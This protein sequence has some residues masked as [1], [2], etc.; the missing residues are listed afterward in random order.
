MNPKR[1]FVDRFPIPI[2]NMVDR[3]ER[4]YITPWSE[5]YTGKPS[6]IKDEDPEAR[7]RFK[8]KFKE[9]LERQQREHEERKERKREQRKRRM[10]AFVADSERINELEEYSDPKDLELCS[11][12]DCDPSRSHDSIQEAPDIIDNSELEMLDQ[13]E[14]KVEKMVKMLSTK[15]DDWKE[16]F[17]E[18][19]IDMTGRCGKL[20]RRNKACKIHTKNKACRFHDLVCNKDKVSM[21]LEEINNAEII[22]NNPDLKKVKSFNGEPVKIEEYGKVKVVKVKSTSSSGIMQPKNLFGFTAKP[23]V[24][25]DIIDVLGFDPWTD[26]DKEEAKPKKAKEKRTE[27]VVTT[28]EPYELLDE[29]WL[30]NYMYYLNEKYE[31]MDDIT[32]TLFGKQ[33]PMEEGWKSL[34]EEVIRKRLG[35][36][37]TSVYNKVLMSPDLQTRALTHSVGI[38]NQSGAP[39]KITKHVVSEELKQLLSLRDNKDDI[40][41]RQYFISRCLYAY[42][43]SEQL[44]SIYGVTL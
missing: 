21:S 3:E 9:S 36:D 24:I 5:P 17:K 41:Q 19:E 43:N 15:V 1:N 26:K 42:F 22:A 34:H 25:G 32:F 6:A 38:I 33:H 40:E 31:I 11:K 27:P 20:T 28:R 30:E 39:V 14:E 2:N 23:G 18:K 44:N 4:V 8:Q 37:R 16:S 10:Q 12:V 7:L 35:E 29:K 13:I